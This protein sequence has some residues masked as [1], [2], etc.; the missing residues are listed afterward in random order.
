MEIVMSHNILCVSGNLKTVTV[1]YCTEVV[2][3]IL[4]TCHEAFPYRTLCQLTIAHYGVN[5]VIS[6]VFF[7]CKS[8][9][10]TY[11]KSMS[12]RTRVHLDSRQLVVWMSDIFG[13]KF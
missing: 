12:K 3:L 13:T 5:T 1:N 2:Q 7:A 4:M 8:H 10:Y 6:V 9:T 11:R